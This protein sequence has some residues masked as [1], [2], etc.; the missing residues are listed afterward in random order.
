MSIESIKIQKVKNIIY[1]Q[2][3]RME[4]YDS[5]HGM[6][7][8]GTYM[9]LARLANGVS[10][11]NE[12]NF[13]LLEEIKSKQ[14]ERRLFAVL[15][16]GNIADR[17]SLIPLQQL[18]VNEVDN[19]L[20]TALARAINK[21]GD[22]EVVSFLEAQLDR[23]DHHVK[24][25]ILQLLRPYGS[26]TNQSILLTLI[27]HENSDVRLNSILALYGHEGQK[28]SKAFLSIL[29]D[30]QMG[31]AFAAMDGLK[32]MDDVAVTELINK[33]NQKGRYT[34]FCATM[35]LGHSKS[36]EAV[37]PLGDLLSLSKN[38]ALRETVATALGKIKSKNSVKAL[39]NALDDHDYKVRNAAARALGNIGDE[40][41]L[42]VLYQQMLNSQHDFDNQ[43]SYLLT[44]ILK[45][46]SKKTADYLDKLLLHED[47]EIQLAAINGLVKHR[48]VDKIDSLLK[49]KESIVTTDTD[50]KETIDQAIYKLKE[51]QDR[52]A[53]PK[54]LTG[55]KNDSTKSIG[56]LFDE[57]NSKTLEKVLRNLK[58]EDYFEY[59]NRWLELVFSSSKDVRTAIAKKIVKYDKSVGNEFYCCILEKNDDDRL[60]YAIEMTGW[61]GEANDIE[62]IIPYLKSNQSH[63]RQITEQAVKK[64]GISKQRLNDI[65]ISFKVDELLKVKNFNSI[66]K[67]GNTAVIAL[68]DIVRKD[69]FKL[70]LPSFRMLID[71][72]KE[73]ETDLELII[74]NLVNNDFGTISETES[75][76]NIIQSF[77]L[78]STD[79]EIMNRSAIVILNYAEKGRLVLLESLSGDNH[80]RKLAAVKALKSL[81][82]NGDIEVQEKITKLLKREDE[83]DRFIASRIIPALENNEAITFVL[84]ALS[85][86]VDL[87]SSHNTQELFNFVQDNPDPVF[88]PVL[89]KIISSENQA[90]I[91]VPLIL[92]M[93]QSKQSELLLKACLTHS[94]QTVQDHA[95]KILSKRGWVPD[96]RSQKFKQILA[97]N[98]FAAMK[99]YTEELF[100]HLNGHTQLSYSGTR[101]LKVIEDTEDDRVIPLF[102]KFMDS[103]SIDVNKYTF[104]WLKKQN[105]QMLP[106]LLDRLKQPV[107]F[108]L[109]NI[110]FLLGKFKDKKAI[111]PLTSILSSKDRMAVK[112]AVIALRKIKASSSIGP[113]VRVINIQYPSA[114][115]EILK[116]LVSLK[117]TSTIDEIKIMKTVDS[118]VKKI[119]DESIAKLISIQ[120]KE[121]ERNV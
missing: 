119:R 17:K 74:W 2:V 64:I 11:C 3:T 63:I 62:T 107:N 50:S 4:S 57:N 101:Y 22:I 10:D 110:A 79:S 48:A 42:P 45:T 106:Y 111:D 31:V 49:K 103:S 46:K 81:I 77:F 99:N 52:T 8:I 75:S 9:E 104:T 114:Q 94:D 59:K 6:G 113:L 93:Y 7:S 41:S 78:Q 100:D 19:T 83:Q 53:S 105:I 66:K 56:E 37:E 95:F 108:S 23:V 90:V 96:Q 91:R 24:S 73:P 80:Y 84:E 109:K 120:Q 65:N 115:K 26:T 76:F 69:Y 86:E 55:R 27:S 68:F 112:E 14:Y 21:I 18:M 70:D 33:L 15:A 38:K 116:T 51:I 58:R 121:T 29:S 20:L 47:K 102:I 82:K 12:A 97:N 35:L 40:K 16:L 117:A 5:G 25:V 43:R 71:L 72:K 85:I 67:L 34:K 98:D 39:C 61:L 1:K 32:K 88:L 13:I 54:K 89:A 60:P 118:S 28:V 44:A 92:D 36:E 87:L 30:P